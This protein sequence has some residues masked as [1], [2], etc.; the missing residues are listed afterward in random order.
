MLAGTISWLGG[1]ALWATS[2]EYCRRKFFE[3]FYKTH[4][5]GLITFF[6]FGY[7][8]HVS[9]WA[10]TMPGLPLAFKSLRPCRQVQGE[11]KQTGRLSNN[12]A[13]PGSVHAQGDHEIMGRPSPE[14]SA[15]GCMSCRDP[16]VPPGRLVP[17]S[18]AGAA[19]CG[20]QHV[21]LQECHAGH[22]PLQPQQAHT[23]QAHPGMAWWCKG[24]LVSSVG[25]TCLHAVHRGSLERP[26]VLAGKQ[27][28][29]LTLSRSCCQGCG[30]CCTS[31]LSGGEREDLCA[32]RRACCV[33]DLFLGV[34]GLSPLQWHPYSTVGG[35]SGHTLVAHIKAYG[36]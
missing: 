32:Q 15:L 29:E 34:D 17:H 31:M 12:L 30:T 33:Q 16:A 6:L 4:I 3:V 2:V 22:A 14:P 5:L 8:H 13:Q 7:M 24:F 23:H 18:A 11:L 10:Y 20:Q 9:L 27:L 26:K 28:T 25:F 21:R 36:K 35:D 1:C 19:C